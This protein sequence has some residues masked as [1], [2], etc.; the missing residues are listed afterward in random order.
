MIES[1]IFIGFILFVIGIAIGMSWQII[2]MAKHDMIRG[3]AYPQ[4]PRWMEWIMKR[5]KR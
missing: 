4:R 2:Y 1:L 5:R 3:W